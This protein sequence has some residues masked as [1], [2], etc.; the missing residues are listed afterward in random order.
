LFLVVGEELLEFALALDVVL[1]E[2]L[3][4]G[5]V[6]GKRAEGVQDEATADVEGDGVRASVVEDA[7][8]AGHFVCF[9]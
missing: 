9:Y 8:D 4:I 5:C 6:H 3:V 7:L 1:G 2:V